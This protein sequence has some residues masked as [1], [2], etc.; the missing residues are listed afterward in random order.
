LLRLAAE[1]RGA[2]ENDARGFKHHL[3]R[4]E[5]LQKIDKAKGVLGTAER[6]H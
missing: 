4:S 2:E 5:W 1:W 3:P 6:L